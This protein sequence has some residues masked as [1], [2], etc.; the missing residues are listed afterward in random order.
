MALSLGV[1]LVAAEIG[2]RVGLP[3]LGSDLFVAPDRSESPFLYN[4]RIG[5]EL[6]PLARVKTVDDQGKPV[7]EQVTRDG[8][9]GPERTLPKPRGIYRILVVGDS[10]AQGFG[11]SYNHS[12]PK[13][14]ED[15][16]N[17]RAA[18]GDARRRY[19]VI[20]AG[21]G[22]YVSW[23][24]LVRL[25]DR[26]LKYEPELVLV[27]VGWND[28]V[29]SS[30][31]RWKPGLGLSDIEEAYVGKPEEPQTELWATV[32]M[33]L[34]RY[35]YA[36]RLV[37]QARNFVWN[38]NRIQALIEAHGHDSGLAFNERAL[39]LY[40]QNLERI[41][42]VARAAGAR[43]GVVIWPTILT[44]NLLDDLDVH[45]R[46]LNTYANFPLSTRELWVWYTRYVNAQREFAARHGDVILID[47]AGAFLDKKKSERLGLFP[48]L[49]HLTVAGNRLL[50][51]AVEEAL[52]QGSAVSR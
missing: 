7:W 1:S 43:T 52:V 28:L 38:R 21:I 3:D 11:V 47:A 33:P 49:A 36:A 9:R 50:A 23:Q 51:Q 41:R 16:L 40:L 22:G 13:F 39:D 10:V 14:L 45:W 37:R 48:D 46:L 20:N 29:Y 2:L 24:T 30:R 34:Y 8:F 18:G 5:Y 25:E 12:W 17:R 26:G 32:R 4:D 15:S 31:P 6:K 19:E 35:S 27:L 44:P 42:R